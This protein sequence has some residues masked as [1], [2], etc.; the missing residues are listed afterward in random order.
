MAKMNK[1]TPRIQEIKDRYAGD[2]ERQSKAMMDLYKKEGFNPLAG[3]WPLLVQFPVFMGLYWVLLESVELRQAD[4]ALWINDLSAPDPFYV[5]PVLF[6]VTFFIQQKW[7]GS[8]A[9]MDPAQ[10][11]IMNVM[12]IIMTAFFAFFQA[13][14]VLY[15]FVSNI[16]GMGQQWLIMRKLDS[17]GLGRK[18]TAS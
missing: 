13:G 9:T 8:T 14:L 11:K 4:F 3:C 18:A 17:E 5:L 1:L 7:S 15:W 10:Q 2:R 12:P 6:G 16:I